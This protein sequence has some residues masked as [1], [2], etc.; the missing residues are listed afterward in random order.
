MY[1]TGP[2]DHNEYIIARHFWEANLPNLIEAVFCR[3]DC[4]R[5]RQVHKAFL[6]AYGRTAEQVPF[7]FYSGGD[8]FQNA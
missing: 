2:M 5:A 3:T 1:D 4:D 8:G 7:L 6:R